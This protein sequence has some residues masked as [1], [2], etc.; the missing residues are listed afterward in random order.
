[1]PR[2]DDLA[3]STV[4]TVSPAIT[5]RA[6]SRRSAVAKVTSAGESHAVARSGQH[7]HAVERALHKLSGESFRGS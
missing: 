6:R 2:V 7:Q 3:S 1:M 4:T 5:V